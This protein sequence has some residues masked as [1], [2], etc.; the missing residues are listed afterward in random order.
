MKRAG[1]VS[2]R[3]LIG[4]LR[5]DIPVNHPD[6]LPPGKHPSDPNR[7]D[8]D[9]IGFALVHTQELLRWIAEHHASSEML[10]ESDPVEAKRERYYLEDSIRQAAVHLQR[11]TELLLAGYTINP[12]LRL[13]RQLEGDGFRRWVERMNAARPQG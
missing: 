9:S 6:I 5:N 2:P 1:G 3:R 7:K 12:N 4:I 8:I 11:L 13:P 10:R